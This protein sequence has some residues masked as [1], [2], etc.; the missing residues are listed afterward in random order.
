MIGANVFSYWFQ[1][2]GE[3][4]NSSVWLMHFFG[5]VTFF[6]LFEAPITDQAQRWR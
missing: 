4:P 6:C 2:T 3:N 5:R 1:R